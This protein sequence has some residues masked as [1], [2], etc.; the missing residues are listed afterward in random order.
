MAG[1]AFPSE[2]VADVIASCLAG[3]VDVY[4]AVRAIHSQ[5]YTDQ[6]EADFARL[7]DA[8]A[9]S[10]QRVKDVDVADEA[11]SV[12]LIKFA[13]IQIGD[14]LVFHISRIL[15]SLNGQIDG[16]SFCKLWSQE[17]L[18]ALHVRLRDIEHQCQDMLPSSQYVSVQTTLMMLSV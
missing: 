8:L 17:D 9:I 2:A 5:S 7:S 4:H 18:A 3:V 10:V 16:I 12:Y 13:C 11:S 1:A 6:C 14:D 15:A